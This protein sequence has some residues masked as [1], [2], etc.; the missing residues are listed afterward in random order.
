MISKIKTYLVNSFK[1]IEAPEKNSVFLFSGELEKAIKL[2]IPV[3]SPNRNPGQIQDDFLKK[4]PADCLKS[5]SIK[6][7]TNK[8]ITAP[9]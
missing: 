4:L 6:T 5:K 7:I 3:K 8:T 9:A 1:A 2:I